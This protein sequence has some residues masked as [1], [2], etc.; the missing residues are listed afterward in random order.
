MNTKSQASGFIAT[1]IFFCISILSAPITVF[2]DEHIDKKNITVL[3]TGANRGLGLELAK[4]FAADGYQVIGTARKP[5]KAKDLKA[6]GARVV[7]LD[8]TSE[9]DISALKEAF[10]GRKIDILINNAGYFGPKLMTQSPDNLEKLTRE[11]MTR[12]INVNTLGPLF[13]TQALLPNL[14]LSK[15]PKVINMSTRSAILNAKPWGHSYGYRVSKTA[16]NMVTRTLSADQAMKGI[17]VVSIAPGHN[18]TDMGTHWANLRPEESMKRVKTLIEG[19]NRKHHG[20]F[21]FY[22]GSRRPW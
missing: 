7:K 16:L 5:E 4:Q 13:V 12:C 17:L 11:E 22:D 3:I 2:A 14:R 21:W 6:T 18:K 9:Q 19:L 15:D 20:G 1:F 8:V 10:K